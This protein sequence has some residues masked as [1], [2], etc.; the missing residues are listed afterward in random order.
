MAESSPE[1]PSSA[2][3]F[4]IPGL[5]L[6][7]R[8]L[9]G[10]AALKTLQN[11]TGKAHGGPVSAGTPY[12]VG[13]RGPELFV[14]SS[15]GSIV[16]NGAGGSTFSISIPMTVHAIDGRDARRAMEAQRPIIADMV[17]DAIRNSGALR[18]LT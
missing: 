6:A 7:G 11:P 4:E 14:P 5:G 1:L 2:L 16:P 10:A 8:F 13:E 17:V 3:G 12:I 15:S 9:S 18:Q